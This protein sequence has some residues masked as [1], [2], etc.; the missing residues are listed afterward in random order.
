MTDIR[1][2]FID[3]LLDETGSMA[4]CKLETITGY[5]NFVKSQNDTQ[6]K[7]YITLSKFDSSGIRIPYENLDVNMV[8]SLSFYPGSMTN[9]YDC[10]HSRL[11]HRLENYSNQANNLFVI[12]TDGEDNTSRQGID[13]VRSL[14]VMAQDKGIMVV[15]MGPSQTALIVGQQLGIPE[16]NIKPFDVANMNQTMAAVTTATKAFRAGTVSSEG[17]FK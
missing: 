10:I 17:F 12:M 2:T 11:S 1:P 4:S 16:G 7:C 6:T 8:P 9:L 3:F 5:D 15:F 13:D 14:I